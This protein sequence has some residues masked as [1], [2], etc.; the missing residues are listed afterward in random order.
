VDQPPVG[1][2]IDENHLR[3]VFASHAISEQDL[4]VKLLSDLVE[5]GGAPTTGNG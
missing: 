5:F 1:L 2:T 3:F 4:A